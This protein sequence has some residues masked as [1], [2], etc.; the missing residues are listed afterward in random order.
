MEQVLREIIPQ[1]PFS[2]DDLFNHKV[3]LA[4]IR[5]DCSNFKTPNFE[6]DA[7]NFLWIQEK[8]NEYTNPCLYWFE[9]DDKESATA[10]I[11]ALDKFRDAQK[12]LPNRRAVPV[13]NNN[14]HSKICGN[15]IYVGKRNGGCRM[16]NGK[17][18][19]IAGRINIH[20]GYYKNGGTQGL[21]LA[22]WAKGNLTLKVIVF[23]KEAEKFLPVLEKLLASHLKPLCGRH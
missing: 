5:I 1:P 17:L 9:A 20:L 15:V 14:I 19:H 7:S 23:P 4:S 12:S 16:R 2:F 8:L 11:N 21:Q 13:S 6:S 22:H 10:F 3:E 18:S